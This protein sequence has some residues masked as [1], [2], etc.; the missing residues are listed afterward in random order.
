MQPRTCDSLFSA[1]RSRPPAALSLPGGWLLRSWPG[2]SCGLPLI[3]QTAKRLAY[4]R[5]EKILRH[6]RRWHIIQIQASGF[7]FFFNLLHPTNECADVRGASLTNQSS[8]HIR[9][10]QYTHAICV[11]FLIPFGI[12]YWHQTLCRRRCWACTNFAAM[13]KD[14]DRGKQE[15]ANN[16][17]SPATKWKRARCWDD[18]SVGFCV[19]G[20]LSISCCVTIPA[21]KFLL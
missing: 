12:L 21:R 11:L 1:A 4:V 18:L 15:H 9:D 6:P 3:P 2:P 10:R 16:C 14:I 13:Y 20:R 7:F 5:G 19:I 17:M 8:A